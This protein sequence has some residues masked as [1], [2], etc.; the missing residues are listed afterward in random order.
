VIV[1]AS[2]GS[3]QLIT[4]PAHAHLARRVME[5]CVPLA[6]RPR[7]DV[8]L[9]A[10]EEHDN[11]WMEEDAAPCLVPTTGQI[12]DFIH[13]PVAVR[14]MVWARALIRLS[15]DLW[16]S[17]LVAQHALVIYDRYRSDITWL[18][19]F[20]EME[21]ER[22]DRCE[23][24]GLTLAELLSDYVF[25]RLADLISLSFCMGTNDELRFDH[26]AVRQSDNCVVVTPD[27][28]GGAEI[29]I[30]I[31][32]MEIRDERFD[33]D[34]ALRLALSEAVSTTLRGVVTGGSA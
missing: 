28:F 16:A 7:R 17:A 34:A 11:G 4:Q 25:V 22:D 26:W 32:M 12:A 5:H 6:T 20:T 30:E 10:I 19:F 13:A 3:I 29:P 24:S 15:D 8:I 9:H 2:R 23:A 33:S 21:R 14:Q 1:R 27:A 18:P 31:R